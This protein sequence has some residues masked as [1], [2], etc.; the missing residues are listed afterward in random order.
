M[1]NTATEKP[2]EPV[3]IGTQF[4]CTDEEQTVLKAAAEKTMRSVASFSK[5]HTLKAAQAVMSGAI[6]E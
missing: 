3:K 5:Y 2:N 6:V 1:S 4:Y